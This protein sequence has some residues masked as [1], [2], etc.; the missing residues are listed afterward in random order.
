[1]SHKVFKAKAIAPR[2]QP[3]GWRSSWPT[4]SSASAGGRPRGCHTSRRSAL[5]PAAPPWRSPH[6]APELT[7]GPTT[8][9]LKRHTVFWVVL[10]RLNLF[11]L[12]ATPLINSG[13]SLDWTGSLTLPVFSFQAWLCGCCMI[14]LFLGVVNLAKGI[15]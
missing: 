6:G 4:A 13:Y 5:S 2:H 1:M 7:Q 9:H 15:R 3:S 14:L 11:R 12:I 10:C 8:Q